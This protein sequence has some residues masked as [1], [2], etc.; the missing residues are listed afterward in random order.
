MKERFGIE[1]LADFANAIADWNKKLG[2]VAHLIHP[3][4]DSISKH[5]EIDISVFVQSW[6][7]TSC[8][9]G[10]IGGSAMTSS[11][12]IVIENPYHEVF[13][14]YY[15]GRCAYIAKMDSKWKAYKD[16]NYKMLPGL[17][18]DNSADKELTI[19]YKK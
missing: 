2:L 1:Q 16:K 13:A 11:Y 14:V 5:N 10:G 17:N 7:S 3:K 9:W 19:L 18:Q 6:G 4:E 15:D 12:T 8:G